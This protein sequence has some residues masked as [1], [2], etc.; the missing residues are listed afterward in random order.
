MSTN[1]VRKILDTQMKVNEPEMNGSYTYADYL[2]WRWDQMVELIHGKI[3]KMSPAPTSLHQIVSRE[4]SLQIGNYLKKKKCQMFSAPFDV[5]LPKSKK[6]GD[7][8]IDTVV[9]PDICVICDPKKI[10]EAGCLGAPDWI[11]EILSPHTSSKDLRN[12]GS[13]IPMKAPCWFLFLMQKENLKPD[14]DLTS[15]L[16]SYHPLPYPV[17]SLT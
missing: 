13:C 17:W 4:L 6:K 15:R 11:I 12:T 2:T 1:F 10:D 9:Q 7:Q 14:Q 3:Y 8:F 16:P 5:R